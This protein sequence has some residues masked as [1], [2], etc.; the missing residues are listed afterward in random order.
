MYEFDLQWWRLTVAM[1]T[2]HERLTTVL[3]KPRQ[4]KE[5]VRTVC[6]VQPRFIDG[7]LPVRLLT[8]RRSALDCG[9]G[10]LQYGTTAGELL[11]GF[12]ECDSG[13]FH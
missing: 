8:E 4:R 13:E 11:G 9:P 7:P 5:Q 3:Q 2:H 12:T 10:E 1:E 6:T